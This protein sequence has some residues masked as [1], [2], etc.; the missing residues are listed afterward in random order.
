MARTGSLAA[1]GLTASVVFGFAPA[2]T[3]GQCPLD[4]LPGQGSPGVNDQVYA[5]T[6]WDPDGPGPITEFLVADGHFGIAC[7]MQ[8][9]HVVATGNCTWQPLGSGTDGDVL[10]L[11]V[12]DEHL[13][14]G[15]DFGFAGGA[16]AAH[17]AMGRLV[18]G[19]ARLGHERPR[20]GADGLRRSVDR[21]RRIHLR[22]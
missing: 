9:N 10:A 22:G 14:A 11:S 16:P 3:L 2:A 19:T 18:L 20:F 8:A 21:R 7:G 4:W 17:I 12:F 6:T 5:A 1:S 13:I 15:G